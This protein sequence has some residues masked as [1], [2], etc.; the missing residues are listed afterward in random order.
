MLIL[1]GCLAVSTSMVCFGLGFVN[2]VSGELA[3]TPAPIEDPPA[4]PS[5]EDFDEEV[6]LTGELL[7]LQRRLAA[8]KEQRDR[9]GQEEM[10]LR[11]ELEVKKNRA[12]ELDK[13]PEPPPEVPKDQE[14]G[15]ELK[16]QIAELERQGRNLR[17]QIEEKSAVDASK[18]FGGTDSGKIPQWVECVESAV[19]L[20]PQGE[21]ITVAELEKE[22]SVF[23]RAL[24]RG[25][26]VF[27]I[28]PSG[29][30]AFKVARALAAKKNVSIGYE[31]IDS[32]W[33]LKF[34]E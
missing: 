13:T 6:S 1:L 25:Y 27:M 29:F 7:E 14:Q 5:R 3:P 12:L 9:M 31:P 24:D 23:M 30:D 22:S 11:Q 8:A 2:L 17:R 33:V 16:R 20:Q 15:D 18:I 19:I 32:D 21:R 26:L 4:V 10:E 34:P 28:R